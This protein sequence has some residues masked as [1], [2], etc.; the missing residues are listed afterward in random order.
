VAHGSG[1]GGGALGGEGSC[2]GGG[3][4][5]GVGGGHWQS[6]YPPHAMGQILSTESLG[7]MKSTDT[8]IH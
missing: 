1:G 3:R 8:R 5:G 4:L 2:G 6:T 7:P